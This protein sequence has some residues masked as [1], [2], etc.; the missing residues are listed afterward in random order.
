MVEV[1]GFPIRQGHIHHKGSS[2]SA[3]YEVNL[4]RGA[5][6]DIQITVRYGSGGSSMTGHSLT[7]VCRYPNGGSDYLQISEKDTEMIVDA[8]WKAYL[9]ANIES[10]AT[11]DG[12]QQHQALS[13][14]EK[15]LKIDGV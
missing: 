9:R 3:I 12:R 10:E 14:I 4:S 7:I 15:K 1:E 2:A 11:L 13:I 5:T 6:L 8:A